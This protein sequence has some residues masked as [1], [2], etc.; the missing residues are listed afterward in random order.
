MRKPTIWLNFIMKNESKVL[1]R[2]LSS[3]VPFIDGCVCVDTGSTDNSIGV[4]GEFFREHNLPCEIH[5]YT[6]DFNF[7]DARQ[8][9]LDQLGS[10]SDYACFIDCDEQVVWMEGFTK[11]SLHDELKNLDLG[12]VTAS[13]GGF[14]FARRMFWRTNKKFSWHYPVHEILLA[15]N[16]NIISHTTIPDELFYVHVNPDGNSWENKDQSIKYKKHADMFLKYIDKH[17]K[18][19]RAVFYLANSYKDMN[20]TASKRE[21]FLWY[22]ERAKIVAGYQEERYYAQFMAGCMAEELN[23]PFEEILKLYVKCFEFDQLRAEHVLHIILLYQKNNRYHEALMY[24]SYAMQN[25]HKKN[26]YPIKKLMIDP[27]TYDSKFLQCH[28]LNLKN[29][30][31]NIQNLNDVNSN[32][33]HRSLMPHQHK[34]FNA[35]TFV[36]EEFLKLKAKFNI[37]NVIETGTCLGA[38]TKWFAENFDHVYTIEAVNEYRQFALR[39]FKDKTNIESILG[40]SEVE[41][42]EV[43]KKCENDTIVFLDAHWGNDCPLQYELEAIAEREI[44]PVIVI[45]DFLNPEHPNMGFDSYNG[46]PFTF[47]W[48]NPL[49][50]N[51]YGIGNYSY[52]YN[53]QATEINRGV[54]YLYPNESKFY[55]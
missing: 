6:K 9:A 44:K 27:S 32:E 17:G 48:L 40:K 19:P 38:T 15:E 47:E 30:G 51:I 14:K 39:F 31:M 29:T 20:T 3:I 55:N 1:P 26:P 42:K 25:Y 4:V 34:P 16:E 21:A 50:D 11:E 23:K 24:S 5:T 2:M 7:G 37:K 53:Q 10:K 52:H 45:H 22:K 33:F 41:I 35:D 46:Q 12:L 13:L 28:Q 54:I 36:A 8:F 49:F 18:D 43:L